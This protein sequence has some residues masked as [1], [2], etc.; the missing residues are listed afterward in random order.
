MALDMSQRLQDF[1]STLEDLSLKEYSYDIPTEEDLRAFEQEYG[2]FLPPDYKEFCQIIGTAT[3]GNFVIITTPDNKVSNKRIKL[4]QCNLQRQ[5]KNEEV[6]E[7]DIEFVSDL[8]DFAFV[9][10]HTGNAEN[11]VWDL[12]TY[13]K[14]DQSYDI[15]FI[16]AYE[17]ENVYFVGRDFCDFLQEFCFGTRPFEIL[18]SFRQPESIIYSYSRC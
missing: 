18:P 10:A 3:L 17:I 13:H 11:I 16:P 1:I 7:L 9:F 14:S 15:Y 12:R 2:F 6:E 8:L 5:I 4:N